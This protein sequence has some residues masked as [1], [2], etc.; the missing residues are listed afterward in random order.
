MRVKRLELVG[1]KSFAEKTEFEFHPGITA[2]VGP[3]GCGKSN[4]VDAFKWVL[5]EQSAKS[6]RG[7]S[8]ED[9]IF[10][11]S[12]T[13]KTK[14]MAEVTL[15]LTDIP[16]IPDNGSD[17][18]DS[19]SEVSITR[20]LFRS[21]ESQYLINKVP[22]RLK[23]I[24]NMFLDTGLELKAYSILEQGKIDEIINS[25][26]EDR[27]FLIEEVAGVMKY[28]VRK[29]E[30]SS[31]LESARANLERLQDIISEVK[32]QLNA[33]DR[34]AKKAERYKKLLEEIKDIEL[35]LGKQEI[36]LLKEQIETL[37]H[38]EETLKTKETDLST[39]QH[40]LV[41]LI[42]EKKREV[43]DLEKRL[44][45]LKDQKFS[46]EKSI[47]ED[48][49]LVA[50]LK[51]ECNN[52]R[53]RL[54]SLADQFNELD[55][56]K[57]STED[58][59]HNIASTEEE[60]KNTVLSLE[61][62]LKEREAIYKALIEEVHQFE[63]ELELKRRDLFTKAEE[64][65][66]IKNEI[67]HII[68]SIKNLERKAENS[69]QDID[70]IEEAIKSIK[71][72]I[73]ETE[74]ELKKVHDEILKE[75]RLRQDIFKDISEKKSSLENTEERL[76]REREELAA[77]VSKL[78]SLKEMDRDQMHSFNIDIKILCQVADIIETPGRYEKAIEAVLGDKLKASVVEDDAVLM[79]LIE[80]VRRHLKKRSGFIAM[81]M[82]THSRSLKGYDQIIKKGQDGVIGWATELIRVKDE[83][84]HIADA[85]L[86]DVVVVE[87]LDHALKLRDNLISNKRGVPFIA[88]LE[89]DVL[90]PSGV[91]FTGEDKGVLKIKRMIKELEKGI[92]D[93]NMLIERTERVVSEIKDEIIKLENEL[94]SVDARIS[95]HEKYAHG[96]RVKLDNLLQEGER[97]HKRHEYINLE[98]KED[99]IEKDGL[100]KIQR[101][102]ESKCRELEAEKLDTETKIKDIQTK[103][104]E[105]KEEIEHM[106]SQITEI[107][108]ELA[109]SKEKLASTERERKRLNDLLEEIERAKVE[110]TEE[111]KKIEGEISTKEDTVREK[112]EGLESK[113]VRVKELEIEIS[114]NVETLSSK[115]GELENDERMYKEIVSELES[116]RNEIAQMEIKKTEL[117]MRRDYLKTDIM[118]NYSV[119][120]ETADIPDH[121][122]EEERERLS[123]LKEKLQAMGPVSLGTLEEY[124][125]LKQRYEFLVKQR[126]DLQ[127]SIDDLEETIRKINRTTQKK[128]TEAFDALNEKFKKVFTLLFGKGRAELQLT[129]GGILNAG[130]E[131]VAQPPG[132]RLQNMMLLSGGEKALTALS[133]LFAGFMI[134]PTP[135]CILDEV[136]APLDE[137]NTERFIILLKELARDIQFITITHN[138]RTMEAADYLYGI[139]MEESGVSKVVSIQMADVVA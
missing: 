110:I 102:R 4:I 22:C 122:E 93:K 138:R 54:E 130:L 15:V 96:L 79:K 16:G 91:I 92:R 36:K 112:E 124:E 19:L 7:E 69:T 27:R 58:S 61:Q 119:D 26:P 90:E 105:K 25:K 8:M 64:I 31:K 75:K 129:E 41:S 70:Q 21:G 71:N 43:L 125:E 49:G 132:K 47:T 128:L 81:E 88:T 107:K 104:V 12:A 95:S 136:D 28:K 32:R 114:E 134:K 35:R 67:N 50:L 55:R 65:S 2:I 111:S 42:E 24:R 45:S 101:E 18:K 116:L 103:I 120:I 87:D 80:Y 115:T 5:G 53:A 123:T 34:H 127:A 86:S 9:V 38:S 98:I 89:G 126:D 37:T 82:F 44:T 48:E 139:T 97:L 13:R 10:S 66:T 137:S 30:A 56:R 106:R 20:R 40:S 94:T 77:M 29:N 59:L 3:N 135:L 109:S 6:L 84:R 113:I 57:S 23:D 78:E 11:G 39:R 118:N 73:D 133:L 100:V 46:L 99:H 76:Y 131:I 1:F 72:S 17:G 52:L 121:V 74:Q 85:L 117:T 14:G 68:L 108:M 60:H 62:E 51:N 33:I 83:F 63:E